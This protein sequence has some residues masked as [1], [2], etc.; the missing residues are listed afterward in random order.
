MVS[1]GFKCRANI[2]YQLVLWSAYY[3]EGMN[4][5]FKMTFSASHSNLQTFIESCEQGMH[6]V[7]ADRACT[8]LARRSM[9][10]H[11]FFHAVFQVPPLSLS[12]RLG[13]T[14]HL[15]FL[16]V[17]ISLGQVAGLTITFVVRFVALT[18][19]F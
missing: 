7:S 14:T 8:A 19:F 18:D 15:Q 11:A 12:S 4:I 6:P 3:S 13:L 9:Q 2:L 1:C 16:N 10:A 17:E 5:C